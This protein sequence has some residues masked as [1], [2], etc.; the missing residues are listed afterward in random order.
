MFNISFYSFIKFIRMQTLQGDGEVNTTAAAVQIQETLG[1][2][3]DIIDVKSFPYSSYLNRVRKLEY[4]WNQ[5]FRNKK[6]VF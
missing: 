5:P 1:Q 6:I 4:I 2:I 3:Y